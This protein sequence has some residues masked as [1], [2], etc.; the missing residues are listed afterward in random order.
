MRLI[1]LVGIA[2]ALWCGFDLW[3]A[4]QRVRR[5]SKMVPSP[6]GD[7]EFAEGG[8]D[9]PVALVV[10]GSG[11]GFDQGVLLAEV[12]LDAKTRWIAPSRF[13]Y[14]R[15]ALPPRASF[16]MQAEAFAY[17]LDQLQ[18]SRVAVV[19]ISHGGPSALLFALQ[20]PD[21]V[22]SLTL[23]SAGVARGTG[24]AQAS[25][26]GAAL[27][28][29]FSNDVLYWIATR[30]LRPYFLR[31]MGAAPEVV[32][33]LT[34]AQRAWIGQWLDAMNPASLR[35]AGALFDNQA[36][37][38]DARI[39]GITAP[40]LIVHAKDDTLQSYRNAEFAAAHIPNSRLLSFEHGGH[41]VLALE[42]ERI[43]QELFA[44]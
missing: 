6:F 35:A 8:G 43:R 16:A 7:I 25:R 24:N 18:V 34:R 40:T 1:L 9:G 44:Q 23:I 12:V 11:G 32:Q 2:G 5:G 30:L 36:E 15:S 20:Y 3:R 10:H 22:T 31:L 19:A 17:L 42:A 29:V 14:L 33:R 4:Y 21:R 39:A 28:K 13:G 37:M 38:P 26:Q 27:V 41:V